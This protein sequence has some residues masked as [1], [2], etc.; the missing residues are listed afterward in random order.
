MKVWSEKGAWP[1]I[2]QL[3]SLARDRWLYVELR[4]TQAALI[5]TQA[6][7]AIS[8]WFIL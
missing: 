5:L 6:A 1:E 7:L 2:Q 4:M 3:D 8:G